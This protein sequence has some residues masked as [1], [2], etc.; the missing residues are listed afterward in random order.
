MILLSYNDIAMFITILMLVV[1][2]VVITDTVLFIL[3]SLL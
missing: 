3:F 1:V 2:V